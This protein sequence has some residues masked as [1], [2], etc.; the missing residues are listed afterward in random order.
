MLVATREGDKKDTPKG[1]PTCSRSLARHSEK[2]T[3][4]YL[5]AQ[6]TAEPAMVARPAADEVL[7]MWAGMPPGPHGRQK[8]RRSPPHPPPPPVPPPPPPPSRRPCHPR[9][10]RAMPPRRC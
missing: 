2:A 9:R 10:P 3:T 4:A 1:E 7:T 5:L 8:Q 6:Y